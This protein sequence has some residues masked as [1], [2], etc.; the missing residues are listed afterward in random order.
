[1]ERFMGE[2]TIQRTDDDDCGQ[3]GGEEMICGLALG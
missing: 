1:M 2:A 3:D